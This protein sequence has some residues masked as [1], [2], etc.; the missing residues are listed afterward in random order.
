[1]IT[2]FDTAAYNLDTLNSEP[3]SFKGFDVL[4]ID[5]THIIMDM[6]V[7]FEMC[8]IAL[9]FDQ[10]KMMAGLDWAS[11][12]DNLTRELLVIAVENPKA[13]DEMMKVRDAA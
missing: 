10:F 5:P 13:R 1:M 8:E 7:N 4:V 11:V 9:I 3:G 12:G 2:S 6:A